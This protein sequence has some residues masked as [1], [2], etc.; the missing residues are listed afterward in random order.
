[1]SPYTSICTSLF[2]KKIGPCWNFTHLSHVAWI[3]PICHITDIVN[4]ILILC[5][6]KWE[7]IVSKIRKKIGNLS[8]KMSVFDVNKNWEF[9]CENWSIFTQKWVHFWCILWHCCPK[10]WCI[11]HQI[12]SQKISILT[13]KKCQFLMS[14]KIGNLGVKMNQFLHKNGRIFG[15]FCGVLLPQVLVHSP[16]NWLAKTLNFDTPKK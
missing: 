6:S 13:T 12:D 5:I 8:Q 7:E 14:T 1:M 3:S 16:L 15:A 10:C 2:F 11:H 9:R 4:N